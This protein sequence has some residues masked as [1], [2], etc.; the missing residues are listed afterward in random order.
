MIKFTSK[1]FPALKAL[2]V[3]ILVV[4]AVTV[5]ACFF[6]G[7]HRYEPAYGPD[8]YAYGPRPAYVYGG[9]PVVYERPPILGDY[10]DHD[11]WHDRD[12][13]VRNN[14]PWVQQHHPAWMEHGHEHEEH[15]GSH[16][17]R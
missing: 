17:Q 2:K 1:I 14:H 16:V 4:G 5:Q 3:M 9:P 8:P 12:W 15:E 10:D 11:A 6:G 7:G 13:W